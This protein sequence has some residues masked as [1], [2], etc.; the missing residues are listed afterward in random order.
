MATV[1]RLPDDFRRRV[2][3]VD[4]DRQVSNT[5]ARQ[6]QSLGYVADTAADSAKAILMA[7]AYEYEVILTDLMMP[8]VDGMELMSILA[9]RSAVTSFILMTGAPHLGNHAS[10]AVNGRLT[11]V[12]AKPLGNPELE[13]ALNQAFEVA[14]KRRALSALPQA[15]AGFCCSKTA[16]AMLY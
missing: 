14:G 7:T 1:S 3:L 4:D 2:L 6:L 10:P 15:A 5:L 13:N 8:V 11:T 16:V 12:L 9:R